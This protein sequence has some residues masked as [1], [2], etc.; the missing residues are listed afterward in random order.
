MV[1]PPLVVPGPFVEPEVEL[2]LVVGLQFVPPLQTQL[3]PAQRWPAAHVRPQSPQ[4]SGSDTVEV[5]APSQS[6]KAVPQEISVS[7][8]P[9]EPLAH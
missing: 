6:L 1:A 3:P 5:H 9:A 8:G 4:F 7:S 2:V